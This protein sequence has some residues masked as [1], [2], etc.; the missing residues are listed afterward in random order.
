MALTKEEVLKIAK[1]SRLEFMDEEI[2]KFQEDLNNIF[3]YI[4]ELNE[5]DTQSVEPLV[6][7][8][9]MMNNFREDLVKPS[10]TQEEAMLNS[11][12]KVDG[13]LIVPKVV[14]GEN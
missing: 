2:V 12:S 10:L 3:N 11:P 13:M 6:Q 7:V 8:N 1:L 5:V 9:H 14:G 4:D